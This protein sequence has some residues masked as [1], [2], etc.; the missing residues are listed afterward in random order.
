MADVAGARDSVALVAGK[1]A[2]VE[3][4]LAAVMQLLDQ[5]PKSEVTYTRFIHEFAI[6][7]RR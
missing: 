1:L 2:D 5:Q 6:P 3:S 7:L 4:K